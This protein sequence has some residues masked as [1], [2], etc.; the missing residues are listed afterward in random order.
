MRNAIS[1][2]IIIIWN[3]VFGNKRNQMHLKNVV[4]WIKFPCEEVKNNF[5]LAMNINDEQYEVMH[6]ELLNWRNKLVAHIDIDCVF[7]NEMRFET[8]Y[9]KIN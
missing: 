2:E 5:I 6:Q 8:K 9:Y 7:D 3:I 4:S 1:D